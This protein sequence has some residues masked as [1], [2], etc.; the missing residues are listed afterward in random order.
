MAR[1]KRGCVKMGKAILRDFE[2]FFTLF[3]EF[4]GVLSGFR[5]I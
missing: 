3:E 5:V 2:R 1:A 4:C